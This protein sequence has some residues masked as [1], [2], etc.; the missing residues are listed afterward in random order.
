MPLNDPFRG[1]LAGYM[2]QA[3]IPEHH[4]KGLNRICFESL[5]YGDHSL[6][7]NPE[8]WGLYHRRNKLIVLND[9]LK[10]NL[11]Q[12]RETLFHEIGHHAEYVLELD[13]PNA[14]KM[15][16]QLQAVSPRQFRNWSEF[17]AVLYEWSFGGGSERDHWSSVF[18][19]KID[20]GIF[21]PKKR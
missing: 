17:F 5:L 21:K 19:T 2:I 10:F 14:R 11:E 20:P 18:K 4:L 8:L 9:G 12:L 15:F 7:G 6:L 16:K 13:L 1:Y 3:K